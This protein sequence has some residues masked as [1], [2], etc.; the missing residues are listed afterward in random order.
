M[1]I[2][3]NIIKYECRTLFVHE[4]CHPLYARREKREY[5]ER[6]KPCCV[7]RL[8]NS[9]DFVYREQRGDGGYVSRVGYRLCQGKYKDKLHQPRPDQN[10]FDDQI[11]KH[12][13]ENQSTFC[14]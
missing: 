13:R 3:T 1:K 12:R 2:K 7:R 14:A 4:I 8:S 9:L 10:R 11:L 5:R 6:G